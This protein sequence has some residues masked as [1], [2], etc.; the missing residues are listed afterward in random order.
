[1]I[2]IIKVVLSIGHSEGW[3]IPLYRV[4]G[5]PYAAKASV[6]EKVERD[7]HISGAALKALVTSAALMDLPDDASIRIFTSE[8][9]GEKIVLK[10]AD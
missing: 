5:V 1:M 8:W 9:C 6:L 10:L 7:G 4:E 2:E 3:P